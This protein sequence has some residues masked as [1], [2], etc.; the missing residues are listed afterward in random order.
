MTNVLPS[1]KNLDDKT[2]EIDTRGKSIEI[3]GTSQGFKWRL[4]GEVSK[5]F[6]SKKEK[7][8]KNEGDTIF[9]PTKEAFLEKLCILYL[10]QEGSDTDFC[11]KDYVYE[12]VEGL[13]EDEVL[14]LVSSIRNNPAFSLGFR[15]KIF[16][17]FMGVATN[18]S[19]RDGLLQ[20]LHADKQTS[21]LRT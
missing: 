8:E 16:Q 19:F 6:S 12:C 21:F 11:V 20:Q 13:S 5:A 3:N 4:Y 10:S 14:S 2:P 15:K 17:A 7:E 1:Q 9:S 18:A